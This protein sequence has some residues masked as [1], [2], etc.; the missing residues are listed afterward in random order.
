MGMRCRNYL[1]IPVISFGLL[2]FAG[3]HG[4]FGPVADESLYLT[5]TEEAPISLRGGGKACQGNK[6]LICHIPPGNPANAHT[7]CVGKPAV[8]PHVRLH[9][10]LVGACETEPDP[11]PDDPPPPDPSDDPGIEC[12]P[13]GDECSESVTCCEELACLSDGVCGLPPIL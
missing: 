3:C 11:P 1:F 7:I 4:Q 6:V 5:G 8:D 2:V 12:I 13:E 10:D 9:G